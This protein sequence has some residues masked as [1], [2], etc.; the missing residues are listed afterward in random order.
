MAPTDDQTSAWLRLH[1]A[2]G[3]RGQSVRALLAALGDVRTIA[4]ASART[5]REIG[6]TEVQAGAI[7]QPD[8]D[9]M[10]A[11]EQWL[12]GAPDRQLVCLDTASYP[13]LLAATPDPP[14]ALFACGDTDLLH[15]PAL[16][17]V[18]S[19]NPTHGGRETAE[20]FA[21]HLARHGVAIASGLAAGIDAAAHT[22]ALAGGGATIAVLGTGPDV[23][24]PANH[25]TLQADIAAHGVVVT[26]YFPGTT[27]RSGQFPARNRIIAGLSLGTLVVEATRRSGSLITAR[28]AGEAG[29]SVFAIPGSIHNPMARGCHQLIRDGAILVETADD[30]FTELGPA[31]SSARATATA[32]TPGDDNARPTPEEPADP[33]YVKVLEA[34]GFDPISVDAL[35]TRTGLTTAELSSM[36]LIMELEGAVTAVPGVGFAR[37]RYGK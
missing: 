23:I 28:L 10:V 37:C 11:A 5:L 22:G 20:S 13:D 12:A 27:A 35:A 8:T 4:E 1:A 15:L 2:T 34:M 29:R 25:R 14:V 9:R 30:I 32:A 17:V 6:L 24:Y 7:L 16:A 33:D 3:V 19:R 36:L 26:E 21:R 31:L 18:G